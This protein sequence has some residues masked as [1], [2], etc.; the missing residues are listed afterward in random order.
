MVEPPVST[1]TFS[2]LSEREADIVL[3]ELTACELLTLYDADNAYDEL[4]AN[5]AVVARDDETAQLAVP[6]NS[7]RNDPVYE[8][9]NGAVNELN[10]VELLIT[11]EGRPVGNTYDALVAHDAVPNSDDVIP[12]LTT[13][14]VPDTLSP[15]PVT[16]NDPVM[17]ALPENGNPTPVDEIPENEP[18]NEPE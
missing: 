2:V 6:I 8:P 7:P 18:E 16:S 15:L 1:S 13:R 10:C 9:V 12:P 14:M 4:I 3:D 5:D 17:T 11:P